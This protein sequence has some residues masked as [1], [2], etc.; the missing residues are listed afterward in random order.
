[1]GHVHRGVMAIGA[2]VLLAAAA[3][4]ARAQ[5]PAA[6][7]PRALFQQGVQLLDE[8][9]YAEAIDALRR[10]IALREAP[11]AVYNLG[12]A[13]RGAGYHHDAIESFRR[14]L[15]VATD[16][17]FAATRQTVIDSIAELERSMPVVVLRIAGTPEHVRIDGEDVEPSDGTRELR[18]DPRP[19]R[20]EALRAGYAPVSREL[21]P[22]PGTRNEVEL[23]V[24]SHALPVHL[25]IEVTPRDAEIRVNGLPVGRGVHAL[26]GPPGRYV[27]EATADGREPERRVVNLVAGANDRMSIALSEESPGVTSRWWFWTAIGAVALAAIGVGVGIYAYNTPGPTDNGSLG[28][29][30]EVLR[31]P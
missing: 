23:D 24:G 13:Q 10:S 2:V 30:V 18:V 27:V 6:G 16:A 9:R 20:F 21:Q 25:S 4:R 7:D 26:D 31:A 14:F 17:R 8:H 11:P 19:H 15:V 28:V 1:M 3:G 22:G 12:L 5:Q 29:F